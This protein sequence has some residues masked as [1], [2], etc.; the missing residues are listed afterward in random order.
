MKPSLF[1]IAVIATGLG[2]SLSGTSTAGDDKA[3]VRISP[4]WLSLHLNDQN[5]IVLNVEV[6]LSPTSSAMPL[7]MPGT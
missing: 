2:F 5:L 7:W 6:H 3:S 4:Q 1:M